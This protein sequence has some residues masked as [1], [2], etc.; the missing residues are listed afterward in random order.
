MS[1]TYDAFYGRIIAATAA[2]TDAYAEQEITLP[3]IVSA[4]GKGNTL[5]VP[6]LKQIDLQWIGSIQNVSADALI[7]GALS[8]GAA[9]SWSA[10]P[11]IGNADANNVCYWQQALSLTTSG[12]VI[13]ATDR[14]F[15][16]PGDGLIVVSPSLTLHQQNTASGV[17]LTLGVRIW[18]DFVVMAEMEYMRALHGMGT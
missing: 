16:I 8:L 18:Y 7:T 6:V 4:A 13:F 11:A 17:S 3:A 12:Q 5:Y 14:S 1:Q 2:A 10:L 9:S 15:V